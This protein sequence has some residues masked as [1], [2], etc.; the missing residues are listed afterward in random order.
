MNIEIEDVLTL[1]DDKD[2]VVVSKTNVDDINYYYLIEDSDNPS[3]MFCYEDKDEL[4]DITDSE[5]IK[6]IIPHLY[7]AIRNKIDPEKLKELENNLSNIQ[8][9]VLFFLGYK[10]FNSV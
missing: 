2:Y 10:Y 4:V 6:K 8:E 5:K 3:V 7:K 9:W 1:D